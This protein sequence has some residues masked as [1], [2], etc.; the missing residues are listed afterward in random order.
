MT[1]NFGGTISGTGTGDVTQPANIISIG[2]AATPAPVDTS[3]V[4]AW[5]LG[6]F[7]AAAKK[8]ATASEN[9]IWKCVDAA[10]NAYGVNRKSIDP[11]E[12]GIKAATLE[13][14]YEVR[15]EDL[16]DQGVGDPA[17]LA[18]ADPVGQGFD[19]F[20]R[21]GETFWVRERRRRRERRFGP[22]ATGQLPFDRDHPAFDPVRRDE[23]AFQRLSA[24]ILE[25]PVPGRVDF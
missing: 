16:A 9:D 20:A 21:G 18:Q 3:R 17:R 13:Q 5:V 8:A 22:R 1:G 2:P 23:G 12:A 4:T 25:G 6:E 24:R 15:T 11:Q 7:H 14:E 10:N 19:P